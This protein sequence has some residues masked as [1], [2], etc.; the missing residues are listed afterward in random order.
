MGLL[1]AEVSRIRL[2]KGWWTLHDQGEG[3]VGSR[4]EGVCTGAG[5]GV[6][7][8]RGP[9]WCGDRGRSGVV[10]VRGGGRGVNRS[11]SGRGSEYAQGRFATCA[12][13]TRPVRGGSGP[14]PGRGRVAVHTETAPVWGR[15]T[16]GSGWGGEDR[17]RHGAAS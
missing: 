7:A 5:I 13:R 15:C 14:G 9:Y 10:R 16:T 1:E 17:D 6:R 3:R 12:G 4:R 11:E 2:G 8:G